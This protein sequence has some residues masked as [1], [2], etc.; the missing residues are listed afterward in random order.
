M[1]T[2]LCK[3]CKQVK[4]A[5]D[6]NKQGVGKGQFQSRCKPC[7]AEYSKAWHAARKADIAATDKLCSTCLQVL[8]REAFSMMKDA[9]RDAWYPISNCKPCESARRSKGN[10][11]IRSDVIPAPPCDTCRTADYCRRTQ[12]DCASFR[13]YVKWGKWTTDY[14]MREVAA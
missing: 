11:L 7:Q 14:P 3:V 12:S 2:R 4:S 10:G 6:F 8:P 9:R 1:E 5:A 13:E